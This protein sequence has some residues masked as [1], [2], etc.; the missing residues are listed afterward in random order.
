MGPFGL[1][2]AGAVGGAAAVALRDAA[3]ALGRAGRRLLV[4]GTAQGLRLNQ[5]LQAL[6][7]EARLG[8]ED[9]AAEAREQVGEEPAAARPAATDGSEGR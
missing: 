4:A 6:A 7:E 2:L 8:L 5:Q 3:P 9:V 1:L